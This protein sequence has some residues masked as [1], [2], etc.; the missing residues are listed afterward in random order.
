MA[1]NKLQKVADQLLTDNPKEK[2][3]FVTEDGQ[4]FFKENYAKLNAKE[5]GLEDPEV[6]FRE[7]HSEEGDSDLETLLDQTE[8][9]LLVAETVLEKVVDVSNTDAEEIPEEKE[10]DHEAVKAV[11][12]LRK[13]HS[14]AI[15]TLAEAS[16]EMQALREFQSAV[17]ELASKDT[18]KLAEAIKNLI[19]V[20]E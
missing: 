14:D 13:K 3:V 9:N 7:G 20:T 1:K 12:E 6:F 10:D 15:A 2:K 17:V 8:E 4:G 5:K 16:I 19:P 11:I 18:T